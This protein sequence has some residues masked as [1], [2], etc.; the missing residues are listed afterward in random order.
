MIRV[1]SKRS[2][3]PVFAAVLALLSATAIAAAATNP[4]AYTT[5]GSWRFQSAPRLHPP[6]LRTDVRGVKTSLAAGDFLLANFKNI[7][8]PKKFAGQGGPLIV[9]RHLQ[10]V[11][12][13]PVTN[14]EYTNNLAL[15]T[16]NG[17]P[18]LSWWQGSIT[19][20]GITTKGT[21]Y[22]VDQ[23]YNTIAKITGQDGWAITQHE[24]IINNNNA[25][26]TAN[27][28]VTVAKGTVPGCATCTQLVDSAVQE[29]DITTGNLLY[30][31]DALQHIPLSQTRQPA[32]PKIPWD[33]YHVNSIQLISGGRFLTSMRNTWAGYLVD[34]ASGSIVWTIGGK[35]SSFHFASNSA[36]FSWQHDIQLHSNGLLSLFDDHCC[37]L[38]GNPKHPFV[39]P[40]SPSRGLLLRL[41]MTKFTATYVHQYVVPNKARYTAFQGNMELLP[42]HKVVVGWGSDP[43]FS[44]F[45]YSGKLITDTAFPTPDLT[46]RS[47]VA[48]WVGLPSTSQL[49]AVAVTRHG[50]TTVYA[51]WNGATN[52]A[53]WRVLA[54][55]STKHRASVASMA[56]TGFET[57][58]ALKKAYHAYEI[59]ALDSHGHVLGKKAFGSGSGSGGS[60][61]GGY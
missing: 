44:E 13:R 55:S 19:A 4:T 39:L 27:K 5:A 59:V 42:S 60:G 41:D 26:V 40:T 53:R 35:A 32:N 38:T 10:P 2:C 15:Q 61:P 50:K 21:D 31:W 51:S 22:L 29:Y 3:L 12:F 16:Y 57:A 37:Q 48:R 33:A 58:V 30:T 45:T 47:Y 24:L 18:A 56:K 49:R 14:G 17:K 20:T 52:V 23:H 43:H 9:D 6:K 7:L 36:K 8:S 54:G 28:L 25:W 1:F 46:Y 34:I 11:W